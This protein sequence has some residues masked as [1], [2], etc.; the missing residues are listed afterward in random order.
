MTD[1]TYY[2]FDAGGA[3]ITQAHPLPV[4]SAGSPS[5]GTI[6]HGPDATGSPPTEPPVL[7]AGVNSSG[8]VSPF[9]SLDGVF[10][11]ISEQ[12]Q[13]Q[14]MGVYGTAIL[15]IGPDSNASPVNVDANGNLAMTPLVAS[16][17]PETSTP[18]AASATFNGASRDG[19]AASPG[20]VAGAYF[21][22]MIYADQVGTATLQRSNDGTTWTPA[23]TAAIAASTPLTLQ[24]PVTARYHR[25]VVENGGTLQTVLSVNTSYT[26]S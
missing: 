1:P 9:K 14:P 3:P 26:A 17:W 10:Q 5:G 11:S 12:I 20:P 15:G 8:N 16:Y 7:I 22:A 21:N 25:I 24:V 13:Y 2:R 18:L 23:A 6:V 4:A 19:G